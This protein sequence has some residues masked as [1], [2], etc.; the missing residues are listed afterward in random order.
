MRQSTAAVPPTAT[1]NAVR[2]S[3]SQDAATRRGTELSG[4]VEPVA[5]GGRRW[6]ERARHCLRESV[7]RPGRPPCARHRPG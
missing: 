2:V 3:T 4:R 7:R 5:P 6:G 1:A